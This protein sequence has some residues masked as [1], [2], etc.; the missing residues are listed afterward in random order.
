MIHAPREERCMPTILRFRTCLL[1]AA[2][3]V[4]SCSDSAGPDSRPDDALTILRVAADAPPLEENEASFYAV[5]G[6]GREGIIY[7]QDG[8]GG[9]GHEYLRF[10]LDN[11]SLMTDASGLPVAMGDSVLIRITVVDPT[12]VQFQFEPAGILFNPLHMPELRIRY[13]ESDHDFNDDGVEDTEDSEI[14]TRLS[15]WRQ[16]VLG[17]AYVKLPTL[18]AADVDEVE[19]R[20]A[21]FSRFAIAY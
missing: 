5:R 16:E 21:G 14:E 12:R 3:L 7:F 6:E 8:E 1:G 4:A 17:G 20:V 15:L 10:T 11:E 2:L 9:R 18:L 19:G 13:D